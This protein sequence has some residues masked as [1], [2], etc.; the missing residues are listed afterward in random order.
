M[1]DKPLNWLK[2]KNNTDQDKICKVSQSIKEEEKPNQSPIS[3]H[4]QIKRAIEIFMFVTQCQY[5]LA[6][7]NELQF[8][9][10]FNLFIYLSVSFSRL[11]RFQINN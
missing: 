11:C 4:S 3:C 1:G 10:T 5:L 9:N 8:N 6:K 2:S 7:S